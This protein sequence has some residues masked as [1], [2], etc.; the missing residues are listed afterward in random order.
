MWALSCSWH[1]IHLLWIKFTMWHHLVSGR[2][3]CTSSLLGMHFRNRDVLQH[4]ALGS[5]SGSQAGGA[6]NRGGNR[7]NKKEPRC[8]H[9]LVCLCQ[10]VNTV[11]VLCVHTGA[12]LQATRY[13]NGYSYSRLTVGQL[14]ISHI[15]WTRMSADTDR[16]RARESLSSASRPSL[17]QSVSLKEKRISV[18]YKT[19]FKSCILCLSK[20]PFTPGAS[21]VSPGNACTSQTQAVA[22]SSDCHY[23]LILCH[24]LLLLSNVRWGQK[25]DI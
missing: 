11:S 5:T 7:G 24:V 15:W 8:Q 1:F 16:K 21:R 12:A 14:S 20:K 3:S 10:S 23:W 22:L 2:M 9:C 13:R 19:A 17:I 25:S 6:R 18:R 4:G